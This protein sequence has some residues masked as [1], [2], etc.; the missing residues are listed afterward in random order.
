M[1]KDVSDG[2]FSWRV[3][4]G[5]ILFIEREET[6]GLVTSRFEVCD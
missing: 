1:V 5:E 3:R 6:R 4:A 2:P